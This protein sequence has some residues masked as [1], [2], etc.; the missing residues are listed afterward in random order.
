METG[1]VQVG[2]LSSAI[3]NYYLADFSTPHP[4]IKQI[5]YADDITIYTSGPVVTDLINGLNI[6]PSQM[7]NYIKKN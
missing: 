4:N 2:V 7:L 1:V 6:Y 3:F 5:K